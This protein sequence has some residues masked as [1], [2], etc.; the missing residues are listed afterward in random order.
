MDSFILDWLARHWLEIASIPLATAAL[1]YAHLAYRASMRGLSHATMAELNAVRIK[2]KEGLNE[3]HQALVSLQL[4]CQD[5]RA[6]WESHRKKN[7]QLL[8]FSGW[9]SEQSPNDR[10]EGE[11]RQFL[12]QLSTAAESVDKMSLQEL[13]ALLQQAKTTALQIQA[14]AGRL[15]SPP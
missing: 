10:V 7:R 12:A 11:G 9:P 8:T 6:K 5:S 4:A 13:E 3:A 15:E 2:A 14:L 1:T